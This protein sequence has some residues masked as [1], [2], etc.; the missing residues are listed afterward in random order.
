MPLACRSC[1]CWEFEN[2]WATGSPVM[3][4]GWEAAGRAPSWIG[5]W[6]P[7]IW[8]SLP[9]DT[10]SYGCSGLLLSEPRIVLKMAERES[11]WTTWPC[12]RDGHWFCLP[13]I[14][15]LYM[16]SPASGLEVQLRGWKRPP[17]PSMEGNHEIHPLGDSR[18]LASF[19]SPTKCTRGF[20]GNW[21]VPFK[22]HFKSWPF[23]FKTFLLW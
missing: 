15:V 6:L 12:D 21:E 3:G 2:V 20:L 13:A 9:G 22:N 14:D 4:R 10:R 7:L 11:V 19:R 8:A 17:A 1:S 16:E 5:D 23:F 18:V